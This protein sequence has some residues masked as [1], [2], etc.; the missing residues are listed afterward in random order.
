[1][2]HAC[3]LLCARIGTALSDLL[4]KISRIRQPSP[5]ISLFR[6]RASLFKALH[7]FLPL[8]HGS[9]D[10][11]EWRGEWEVSLTP[12]GKLH[13]LPLFFSHLPS[14]LQL[15]LNPHTPLLRHPG[16]FHRHRSPFLPNLAF[17]SIPHKNRLSTSLPCLG[18]STSFSFCIS[19]HSLQSTSTT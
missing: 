16:C 9:Y 18:L 2:Q 15:R 8:D 5:P 6:S 1:M 7:S 11:R 10:R 13:R 3:P 12:W 14:Q 17:S 4:F 19:L